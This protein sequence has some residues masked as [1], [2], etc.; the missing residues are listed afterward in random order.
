M[1]FTTS[2]DN[3]GVNMSKEENKQT[4][5]PFVAP[6]KI[7]PLSAPWRWLKLGLN[8][9]RRAPI[10]SLSYG[11]VMA[12]LI[13]LELLM[14]W[15]YGSA[16]IMLSLLCGFVFAAPVACIGT[17]AISAQLERNQPV[18][19]KRTLQACFNHYIG[20]AMVF[21]LILLVVFLVWA[22]AASMVSIFLPT[23]ADAAFSEMAGYIAILSLVSLLFLSIT[24]AASVFA[25]PM[26]MHRNVDTTTAVV[27]SFNAVM[28]NKWV[29]VL[30]GFLVGSILAFGFLTAGLALVVLLPAIGHAVWHGYLDTIDASAFP[31][32]NVGITSTPKTLQN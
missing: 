26:I 27:T 22:R 8:D 30:W 24:F 21:A 12:A 23:N 3:Y 19:F 1:I 10:V 20:N 5:Y 17:Y 11:A 25:L 9:V 14:A 29:M 6:C 4:Q 32:H 2:R 13:M 16:W 28:H 7:L 18:S 31:R 15:H